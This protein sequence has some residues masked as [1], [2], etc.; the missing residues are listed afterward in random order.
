M[1]LKK[2]DPMWRG[3]D[4]IPHSPTLVEGE[5]YHPE[6]VRALRTLGEGYLDSGGV[7]V[8]SPHYSEEGAFPIN[9]LDPIPE[10]VDWQDFP[11]FEPQRLKEWDGLPFLAEALRRT[12]RR[13]GVPTVYKPQ[14]LDHGIWTPLRWIFPQFPMPVLPVGVCELGPMSHFRMGLAIRETVMEVPKPIVI[15]VSLNLTQRLD[16]L[17]WDRSEFPPEGQEV[18]QALL[19][20]MKA[21][22]WSGVDALSHRSLEKARP[23]GGEKLWAL[24]RGLSQGLRGEVRHY[25]SAFGAVGMAIVHFEPGRKV[26]AA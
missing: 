5:R 13:F 24:L 6:V 4:L 21:G 9:P 12:A 11:G 3:L 7:L 18:D 15:F 14:G 1:N 16:W 22:D 26:E 10:V 19:F 2:R 25:E 23:E 20:A 8:V 17:R